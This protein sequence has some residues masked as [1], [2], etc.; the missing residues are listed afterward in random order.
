MNDVA[1]AWLLKS[2]DNLESADIFRKQRRPGGTVDRAYF[3]MFDAAKAMGIAEGE[4]YP[5][6]SKWLDAF[7]EVFVQKGRIDPS[8]FEDLREA[9]RLRRVAVY[10]FKEEDRISR[11]VAESVFLKATRFVRMAEEFLGGS[12][13]KAEGN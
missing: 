9:Y 4:E 1:R 2:R 6:C 7:G 13:S 3:S 5:G 11:D 8:F 10:G 12:E